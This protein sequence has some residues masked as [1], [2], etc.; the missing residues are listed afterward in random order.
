MNNS[1]FRIMRTFY[2]IVGNVNKHNQF[3]YDRKNKCFRD[4]KFC[5]GENSEFESRKEA[6]KELKIARRAWG[7]KKSFGYETIRVVDY[8][9]MTVL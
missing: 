6:E 2:K 7:R 9:L 4:E 5:D 3:V 1:D 8:T